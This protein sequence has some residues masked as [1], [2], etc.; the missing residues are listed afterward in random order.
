MDAES[1][2]VPPTLKAM[3]EAAPDATVVANRLGVI[4]L[5]NA[6]AEN[7]FGYQANELLGQ[8]VEVLIPNRYRAAHPAH[9]HRY[10]QDPRTRPMGVGGLELYGLRKDGTEFP[11]EISLSQVETQD[12]V[13]A[14]TAIR[15]STVRRRVESKFRGLLEAAPDAM[16]IADARGHIVLVNAQAE[17]LFGYS[18]SELLGQL[19]EALIPR[20]FRAA[21]GGHRARYFH[22]PKARPM[23]AGELSLYGLR[24]DSTEFPAEIS[25]SPLETEEGRLAI[26]AIRDITERKRAE[27]E[28]ARLHAELQ[29]LLADQ[30][31]FFTNLS[32]E[33]RTPLALI[34]GPVEKLI[35]SEPVGSSG[36][37][38]LEVIARNARTL[39]RHVNDLLDVAKVEAGQM[40]L[41]PFEVDVA[42]I[43]RAVTSNFEVAAAE[44][45]VRLFVEAPESLPWVLDSGKLQRIVLNLLSNALKFTPSSGKIRVSLAIADGEGGGSRHLVLE[46]ADSG[47]GVLPKHREEIFIRFRQLDAASHPGGTGLG[48]AIVKDFVELHGGRI[49]V[50]EAREGGALFRVTLPLASTT[51]GAAAVEPIV[52]VRSAAEDLRP[53]VQ[54]AP[55]T[56]SGAPLVLVVEDNAEMGGFIR[57][58]LARET[59]VALASGGRE[60]FERAKAL[61]PDLVLT[62]LMMPGGSGEEL[63]GSM[64][65][66]PDLKDIPIVVLSAKADDSLRVRLLREGAQDYLMKPFAAEELRARVMGL[67]TTKR[68]GDVLRRELNS[69][70]GDV[71]ALAVQLAERKRELEGSLEAGRI[72]R[73][74]AE[75]AN[76]AKGN[77]LALVSHELRTPLAAVQ[78][79]AQLLERDPN[80]SERAR[81]AVPRIVAASG[82]LATLVEALLEQA[83]IASGRLVLQRRATD[84]HQ[85]ASEVLEEMRPQAALKGIELSLEAL[86]EMGELYTD[87]RFVRIILSNLVS[88]AVKFT[89]AGSVRVRLAATPVDQTIEVVD[90]GPG[91]P[92]SEQD[93]VFEAFE[94]LDSVESKHVPGVGLGLAL[95]R[96]LSAALGARIE[97]RSEVGAGS[98]FRV[99]IPVAGPERTEF[100]V[101]SSVGRA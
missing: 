93:R 59:S 91:I 13:F 39:A 68:A 83:R 27:E 31:H 17:K 16:V 21:H 78:L 76:R 14:I 95:V 86:P 29:R 69:K 46:V 62:D 36:R 85:L 9:R 77:F 1:P 24:K 92:P 47:P 89:N 98:S 101:G 43:L 48:L 87:S 40:A 22:D 38:D 99:A 54:P 10:F 8:A 73:E 63:V 61:R 4:V 88:N 52:D 82:R 53:S 57:D 65:A 94:Q 23:G 64:R 18:R 51:V 50:E 41:E 75:R 79:Q 71:E 84:L 30:K 6:Q 42:R 56:R 32:H 33:L 60:G 45:K 58:V 72:A 35:A 66:D 2:G 37:A 90:T 44:R 25:L 96:E 70:A 100:P 19:V 81:T 12:G 15:D 97:L 11:A 49:S 20:R 67:V 28:R 7:L 34:L 80:S 5:V 55:V 74:T 26:T 3:L